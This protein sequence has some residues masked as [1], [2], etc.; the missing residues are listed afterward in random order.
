MNDISFVCFIYGRLRVRRKSRGALMDVHFVLALL[1]VLAFFRHLGEIRSF[2]RYVFFGFCLF[3]S[4]YIVFV[5]VA[6]YKSSAGHERFEEREIVD[7]FP[8]SQNAN[9]LFTCLHCAVCDLRPCWFISCLSFDAV[10]V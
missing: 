2:D 8:G 3:F 10:N 4:F 1:V 5:R 7:E 9:R 6:F